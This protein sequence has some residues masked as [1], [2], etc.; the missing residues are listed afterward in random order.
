MRMLHLP[1][2]TECASKRLSISPRTLQA[3]GAA[4]PNTR[5]GFK[6]EVSVTVLPPQDPADPAP[7][8]WVE[9]RLFDVQ[10][11]MLQGNSSVPVLLPGESRN[12]REASASRAFYAR[13]DV[14]SGRIDQVAFQAGEDESSTAL[15]KYIASMLQIPL[16]LVEDAEGIH[17]SQARQLG[18]WS[19]DVD[20]TGYARALYHATVVPPSSQT[21]ASGAASV[22]PTEVLITREVSHDMYFSVSHDADSAYA[23]SDGLVGG[24]SHSLNMQPAIG[25]MPAGGNVV[26]ACRTVTQGASKRTTRLLLAQGGGVADGN[27][28]SGASDG[29]VDGAGTGSSVDGS[30]MRH[31]RSTGAATSASQSQPSQQSSSPLHHLG[32]SLRSGPAG[33]LD[34]R[35]LFASIGEVKALDVA[36]MRT[37]MREG[38]AP[39]TGAGIMVVKTETTL[40]PV[41]VDGAAPRRRLAYT[42]TKRYAAAAAK[43]GIDVACSNADDAETA[44]ASG[45]DAWL[46]LDNEDHPAIGHGP[47][48]LFRALAARSSSN[49]GRNNRLDHARR[50]ADPDGRVHA[51]VDLD[52]ETSTTFI[53]DSLVVTPAQSH[54]GAIARRL[55]EADPEAKPAPVD[56]P[57]LVHKLFDSLLCYPASYHDDSL[58]L[59][60]PGIDSPTGSGGVTH[61]TAI[62]S[63]LTSRH[64][65]MAVVIQALLLSDPCTAAG[66]PTYTLA[67]KAAGLD[68][69][70][71]LVEPALCKADGVASAVYA[72]TVLTNRLAQVLIGAVAT[73]RYTTIGQ[74]VLAHVL[75]QPHLYRYSTVFEYAI[76]AAMFIA[77]P[78][79]VLL[80]AMMAAT[81]G[82]A[83]DAARRCSMYAASVAGA[84]DSTSSFCSIHT[85][86]PYS[87]TLMTTAA[88]I[89]K[90]RDV[91]GD[92]GCG[93]AASSTTIPCVSSF[94]AT[95]L[96]HLDGEYARV[97]HIHETRAAHVKL[98]TEVAASLWALIP[99]DGKMVWRAHAKDMPLK[100]ASN[101][102]VQ[103]DISVEERQ[104]WDA[105]A[106]ATWRDHISHEAMDDPKIL[107]EL[108]AK[109]LLAIVSAMTVTEQDGADAAVAVQTAVSTFQEDGEEDEGEEEDE[110]DDYEEAAYRAPRSTASRASPPP[111]GGRAPLTEDTLTLIKRL[112]LEATRGEHPQP[113]RLQSGDENNR[114]AYQFDRPTWVAACVHTDIILR[115]YGNLGHPHVLPL[116]LNFTLHADPDLRR[117]AVS[118]M[119]LVPARAG[120]P[121]SSSGQRALSNIV[122]STSSSALLSHVVNGLPQH[123]RSPVV[124]HVAR[125]V[126]AYV[127]LQ[128][129]ALFGEA[130]PSVFHAHAFA[131]RG[132]SMAND[133]PDVEAHLVAIVLHHHDDNTRI[134]ALTSLKTMSDIRQDTFDALL[135]Y[136]EAHLSYLTA[137][138]SDMEIAVCQRRCLAFRPE[139]KSGLLRISRCKADCDG[140]CKTHTY[141]VAAFRRF[142]VARIHQAVNAHKDEAAFHDRLHSLTNDDADAHRSALS[143]RRALSSA[144]PAASTAFTAPAPIVLPR[145]VTIPAHAVGSPEWQHV[146]LITAAETHTP[147]SRSSRRRLQQS[148]GAAVRM[149]PPRGLQVTSLERHAHRARRLGIFTL[150]DA[151]IGKVYDWEQSAGSK[152]SFGAGV[153]LEFK[154]LVNIRVGLFDGRFLVDINNEGIIWAAAFGFYFEIV[155]AQAALVAGTQ[156]TVPIAK[157]LAE[158]AA[159]IEKNAIGF[160]TMIISKVIAFIQRIKDKA[161]PILEMVDSVAMKAF[162]MARN[163]TFMVEKV[164]DGFSI[165]TMVQSLIDKA[166]AMVSSCPAFNT[167]RK[168]VK[169]WTNRVASVIDAVRNSTIYET[170]MKVV[171]GLVNAVDFADSILDQGIAIGSN[172]DAFGQDLL[173]TGIGKIMGPVKEYVRQFNDTLNSI[174]GFV[175]SVADGSVV[176]GVERYLISFLKNNVGLA[177]KFGLNFDGIGSLDGFDQLIQQALAKAIKAL[178][179]ILRPLNAASQRA[180]DALY[181]PALGNI[182][183]DL[184]G[185]LPP[186]LNLQLPEGWVSAKERDAALK[187]LP[188]A[189]LAALNE[190]RTALTAFATSACGIVPAIADMIDGKSSAFAIEGISN[191]SDTAPTNINGGARRLHA[192]MHRH[193]MPV[194]VRSLALESNT[195]AAK[196]S[197]FPITLEMVQNALSNA[198]SILATAQDVI[199]TINTLL[200]PENMT[201]FIKVKLKPALDAIDNVTAKYITPR[202]NQVKE[203][204]YT[205]YNYTNVAYKT[206]TDANQMRETIKTV[207]MLIKDKLFGDGGNTTTGANRTSVV[208]S[209]STLGRVFSTI[210]NF[211]AKA[212]NILSIVSAAFK[213]TN[214]LTEK[215]LSLVEEVRR[216][217]CLDL[218]ALMLTC[219]R[220]PN[221]A[222]CFFLQPSLLA[223]HLTSF[224]FVVCSCSRSC[225]PRW[226]SGWV[227]LPT[228]SCRGWQTRQGPSSQRS[229]S[230]SCGSRGGCTTTRTSSIMWSSSAGWHLRCQ[231]APAICPASAVSSPRRLASLASSPSR[232]RTRLASWT[233]SSPSPTS[234]S[235]SMACWVSWRLP[236]LLPAVHLSPR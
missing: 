25:A 199:Q 15:K 44:A 63:N 107:V 105:K 181:N 72:D 83:M 187:A 151:I 118:A 81:K 157:D 132:L 116:A 175:S 171:N 80:D 167:V 174:V 8:T 204:V 152:D 85:H 91:Y 22:G 121:F 207:V 52:D 229:K 103:G 162:G 66:L 12:S 51:T 2:F 11:V 104:Q 148:F 59:N 39:G 189:S 14:S 78:N 58:P 108:R 95:L 234:C 184:A 154:N 186:S 202:L 49:R 54:A 209:N 156:Y 41:K 122:D 180:V 67:N 35:S 129:A 111:S 146:E 128:T 79:A 82:L 27:A 123:L 26:G 194:L 153:M 4:A 9:L 166:I 190:V 227:S 164:V 216:R 163:V 191:S 101:L 200:N 125:S 223:S 179:D 136:Y 87:L 134:E 19:N 36:G 177:T 70:A 193:D 18:W 1:R 112:S 3:H 38:S 84:R 141:L 178:T 109:T 203:L 169:T 68:P 232:P 133:D 221:L 124:Q 131:G 89:R 55:A 183:A 144:D 231:S 32:R 120:L 224:S 115:A 211:V 48:P 23:A 160:I 188:P 198:S 114:L 46:S 21:T 185:K 47:G 71:L 225:S 182:T 143:L 40:T 75:T 96:A 77:K 210:S 149:S 24:R 219:Q 206:V 233:R 139:C 172:L 170:A 226:A 113:R 161:K 16:P 53:F 6:G 43:A 7:D 205:V 215:G 42:C 65:R 127:G 69:Q 228:A 176:D 34:G 56:E 99:E 17:S 29:G 117:A 137:D 165:S 140:E 173:T 102:F 147:L 64:P 94:E 93:V 155:H 220:A 13:L 159:S 28:A 76:K 126:S 212:G 218:L 142:F 92:S 73:S 235:P 236:L 150:V 30:V 196:K 100:D 145:H 135:D 60:L 88:M 90:A 97:A 61:C 214:A 217:A 138:G 197:G 57:T 208:D 201:A 37:G 33:T 5:G 222:R 62:V 86:K 50:L 192:E 110:D 119:R 10:R 195:T 98:A 230:R 168:Y 31:G 130:S 45:A 106:V 158:G 74:S 213:D 20:S